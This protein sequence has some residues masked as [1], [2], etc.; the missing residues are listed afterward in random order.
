[1]IK[2]S[3]SF[4]N[5]F[6]YNEYINEIGRREMLRKVLVMNSIV[7]DKLQTKGLLSLESS[8]MLS[9]KLRVFDV[10]KNSNLILK[11]GENRLVFN[12]IEKPDNYIFETVF[13][14]LENPICAV[15]TNGK[16]ILAYGKT[17]SFKEDYESLIEPKNKEIDD[18]ISNHN[19]NKNLKESLQ[20]QDQL[21]EEIVMPYNTFVQSNS[22][23]VNQEIKNS[24]AQTFFEMV[25][26]QVN[27]LFEK[28]EEFLELE[29]KIDNTKWV[30]VPY[31]SEE[32]D[33]Y[34]M[35]K[36]YDDD[37][38]AF[39]GYGIPA[40]NKNVAPPV[41]LE[42]FC[43]WLPLD[44]NNENSSGYWVMYQDATTGQNVEV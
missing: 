41:N 6:C 5:F 36:I 35:G 9:G 12:D 13:H 1:M 43:Q 44:A 4:C 23:N 34:I 18:N 14:S 32:N 7:D 21:G 16:E 15:L 26:P 3:F 37:K 20:I 29:Q 17:E 30:K 2:C 11:I 38:V 33:H 10:P 42:K 39:L 27:Q 8:S 25:E 40:E 31:V 28:S 24:N 19:D 22:K